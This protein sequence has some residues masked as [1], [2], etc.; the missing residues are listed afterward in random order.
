MSEP[1]LFDLDVPVPEPEP[2]ESA[3]VR[4][5]KRQA[6]R[7]AQGVHPLTGSRLHEEAA[8]ADDRTAPGRRCGNCRFRQVLRYH[9]KSYPKCVH[10]GGVSAEQLEKHGPPRV[11][12]GE[13]SDVKAFWSACPDHEWGDGKIP[14]SMRWTPGP[15]VPGV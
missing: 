11:T 9:D 12:H 8:P 14:D 3:T 15:E 5:T 2:K 10:P 4:R 1:T 7:L 13:A 6:A